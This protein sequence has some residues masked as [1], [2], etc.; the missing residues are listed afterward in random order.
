MGGGR[1]L[2]RGVSLLDRRRPAA[3]AVEGETIAWIGDDH[4]AASWVD[5]ATEVRALDGTL[6]TPGFVDAHVHLAM[7][8]HAL[9]GLDLAGARSRVEAL[10]RLGVHTSRSGD[11]VVHGQGWD[12]TSWP[13]GTLTGPDLDRAAG[14]RPVYLG[15]VDGH[16]GVVSASLV[17]RVHGLREADGWSAGGRVERDAHH[18]VRQHLATL[19]DPS[20][21]AATIGTALRA[22]AAAGIVSVH[23]N[24]APHISPLEDVNVVRALAAS[25]VLPHVV[26][27]WG[28]RDAYADARAYDVAGLAGDL[29][30]DGSLGSHTAALH[31]PYDDRPSTI[32]HQYLEADEVAEHVVGCTRAGLQAGFHVIGDRASATL[33]EGLR[34][35]RDV[36]GTDTLRAARHRVE[37]LEMPSGADLEL[38]AQ[39]GVT[40][41]VQPAFDAAWGGSDGMYAARLGKD[42]SHGM[43]PLA[44]M[45]A[46]GVPLA[47]GSD[48]PVTPLA[49]WHAIAAATRPQA[50]GQALSLA[51]AVH[52]HTVGGW[53]A[54]R[55]DGTGRLEPGAAAHLA[56]W[57][58]PTGAQAA[59]AAVAGEARCVRTVVSGRTAYEMASSVA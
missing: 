29:N 7:T 34:R 57:E 37:H 22:A 45:A 58:V 54:A 24:A 1:T 43:N 35:A 16:S 44:A 21:R 55:I 32:G 38:L 40:A 19:S 8:G 9:R 27:Y 11:V 18:L 4:D 6:L 47:F 2:Y 28:S 50:G 3:L 31:E 53:R 51:Q 48:A 25:E 13:D 52:A 39:L 15:R 5:G 30:I 26:T 33:V 59:E 56:F 20:H 14:G 12:D 10:E 17:S 42:R 36:L 23:E 46:I 49:P 41:S